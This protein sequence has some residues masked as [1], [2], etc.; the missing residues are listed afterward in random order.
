MLASSTALHLQPA[1][2]Q[3]ARAGCHGKQGQAG[4]RNGRRGSSVLTAGRARGWGWPS[5]RL[6]TC[7]WSGWPAKH[8]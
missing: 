8:H 4:S 6:A 1:A 5:C 2:E 7:R 3:P